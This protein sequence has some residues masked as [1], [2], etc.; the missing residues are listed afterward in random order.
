M[1]LLDDDPSTL[2]VLRAVLESKGV[3]VLESLDAKAAVKH[4]QERPGGIDVLVADVILGDT[5]GPAV[6]R[7]VKYL[8]PE[9][10]L[11]FIS[12]FALEDLVRRGILD[13]HDLAADCAAF[14]QKPFTAAALLENVHRLLSSSAA[15]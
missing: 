13:P 5:N 15:N 6:V 12:G 14:L 4:C 9:M 2:L 8:Q 10:R 11:L 3:E 7:R 1:L